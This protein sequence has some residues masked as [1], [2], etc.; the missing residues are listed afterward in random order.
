LYRE[1]SNLY[2][3]IGSKSYGPIA[4]KELLEK[5]RGKK[6]T[7]G[8]RPEKIKVE[9]GVREAENTFT[10]DIELVEDT[11]KDVYINFN[12][13]EASVQAEVPE[14]EEWETG[15]EI[16]FGFETRDV[17]LFDENGDRIK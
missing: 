3:Q 17:M 10:S 16:T 8:I 5:P 13:G 9:K 11:G 14:T 6:L 2:L 4:E 7:L 15:K 1:D 12:V